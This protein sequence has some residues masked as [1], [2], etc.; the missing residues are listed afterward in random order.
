MQACSFPAPTSV[1]GVPHPRVSPNGGIGLQSEAPVAR[2]VQ[3]KARGMDGS[4]G[5]GP[6]DRTPDVAHEWFTRRRCLNEF[7]SLLF[8]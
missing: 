1:R 4:I 7:I 6:P 5:N 8:R 2:R 3:V